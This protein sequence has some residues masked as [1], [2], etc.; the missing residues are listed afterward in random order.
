M[1]QAKGLVAI[2]GKRRVTNQTFLCA[3]WT[4]GGKLN[5]LG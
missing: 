2:E 4:S 1:N 3:E 5:V